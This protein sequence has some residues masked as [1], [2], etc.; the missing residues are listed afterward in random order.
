MEVY[1]DNWVHFH[2]CDGFPDFDIQETGKKVDIK[3]FKQRG[4]RF[5]KPIHNNVLSPKIRIIRD[6]K[7]RK[8]IIIKIKQMIYLYLYF[9]LNYI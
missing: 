6:D 3:E 2:H 7:H 4:K 5:S 9:I 1:F 8:F